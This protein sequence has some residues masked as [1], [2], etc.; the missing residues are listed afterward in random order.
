MLASIVLM[1][2]AAQA[3]APVQE[4]FE[5]TT[6]RNFVRASADFCTGGQPRMEHFARLKAEGIKAVVNLRTPVEHNAA[7]ERE[8]V[9]RAGLKYFSIPVI[10]KEPKAEQADEFLRITD[11]PANRPMFIHCTAAIRVGAFWLIRRVVRDGWAWDRAL[12]DARKVGLVN[13]P[14][15]EEFARQYIASHGVPR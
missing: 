7:E 9:E 12:E 1:L 6:I 10:Y 8:A 3:G 15:L 5:P 11:D 4:S 2:S 13:A 14:H